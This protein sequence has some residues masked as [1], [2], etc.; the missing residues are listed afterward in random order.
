M[1]FVL[2]QS[3]VI[4]FK[5]NKNVDINNFHKKIRTIIELLRNNL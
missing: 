1:S 4:A 3:I 2:Q 5:F